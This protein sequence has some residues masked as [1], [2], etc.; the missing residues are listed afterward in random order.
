MSTRETLAADRQD[1]EYLRRLYAKATDGLG[2]N[3]PE[4]IAMARTIYHQIF[5]PD[6][7]IRTSNTGA[8]EPLSASSPEEWA[9]VVN[10]AL[11]H[12]VGTQHL[13]GTQL[14]ELNGDEAQMES[15]VNAWHK[16]DDGRVYS[17]LGTY[18]DKVRR[19][20]QG[21]Q[22]YDMELRHDTSGT[23]QTEER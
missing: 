2:K 21:W 17:Y 4:D 8:A 19:T 12:F 22:I 3:T 14:V 1:I 15:Y 23:V 20:D 18:I 9:D 11:K 10:G 5:T 16:Y 13:I 7:Q 6:V